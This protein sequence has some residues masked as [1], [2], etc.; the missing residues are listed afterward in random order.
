MKVMERTLEDQ[1]LILS[2]HFD[3]CGKIENGLI[4]KSKQLLNA[5]TDYS[6]VI[7]D[8]NRVH[9]VDSKGITFLVGLYKTIIQHGKKFRMEGLNKD[10]QYLFHLLNFDGFYQC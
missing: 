10:I 1:K 7:I 4:E 2:L 6:E 5:N 9:T 3:L 8:M